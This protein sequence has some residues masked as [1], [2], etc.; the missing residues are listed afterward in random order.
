VLRMLR[1]D[2]SRDFDR[3]ST[4]APYAIQRRTQIAMNYF[5]VPNIVHVQQMSV[6][7]VRSYIARVYILVILLLFLV[8]TPILIALDLDIKWY[9]NR[10]LR[11]L[12]FLTTANAVRGSWWDSLLCGTCLLQSTEFR[13]FFSNSSSPQKNT[14]VMFGVDEQIP[15]HVGLAPQVNKIEEGMVCFGAIS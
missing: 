1:F 15:L 11:R 8:F 12:T 4:K 14:K 2:P 10:P 5:Y 13:G 9:H 3:I 6:E 7:V